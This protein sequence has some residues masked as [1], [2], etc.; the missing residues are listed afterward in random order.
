VLWV[1][2]C[3]LCCV[4]CV[5]CVCVCVCVCEC[6]YVSECVTVCMCVC[7]FGLGMTYIFFVSACMPLFLCAQRTQKRM[8]AACNDASA[9][10]SGYD[11]PARAHA[12][13]HTHTCV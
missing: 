2:G 4:V 1:G 12:R 7:V 6:V 3:M 11:T 9:H 10:K 5:E 13:A 8:Q